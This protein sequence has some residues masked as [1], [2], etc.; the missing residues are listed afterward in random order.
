MLRRRLQGALLF[1]AVCAAARVAS[2]QA[3]TVEGSSVLVFPHV[4]ADGTWDTTIQVANG[5]N[6][7]AYARC[8]YVNGAPLDSALP[9]GPT[10]PPQW[11]PVDFALV[12][13]HQQPTHWSVSRGRPDDP[14]DQT[15]R[16]PVVDCD[17]AGFDPGAVPAVPAGFTGELRCVEVD[18]SGAP[19]S[20]NALYGVATLTHLTSREVVKYPAVGLPGF[21]TNNADDTLCLAGDTRSGCALGGEYGGCPLEWVV[22]HPSDADDRPTDGAARATDLTVVPCTEN[23]ETQVPAPMTLMFKVTNEF[24]QTFSAATTVTCWADLRLSDIN[25]VFA[26]ST[27]GGDWALTQTRAASATPRGY[28]LV[29]HTVRETARPTTLAAAAVVPAHVAESVAADAITLPP[30]NGQ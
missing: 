26:R 21:E 28:M 9:P 29:Q 23:F 1:A 30:G 14:A 11:V 18:A 16:T 7:P 25:P 19:W 15:C 6:R 4:V 24:E 13:L 20:G 17:G 12:L 27:L 2:G 8:F 22:S 5:A 10:N 3:T